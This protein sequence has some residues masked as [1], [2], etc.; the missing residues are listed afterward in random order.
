[1]WTGFLVEMLGRLPSAYR[2]DIVT[3]L[4]ANL[5][6][7]AEKPYARALETMDQL[8]EFKQRVGADLIAWFKR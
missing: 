8:T 5:N 1:M 2:D 3:F 7:V 6:G 4:D